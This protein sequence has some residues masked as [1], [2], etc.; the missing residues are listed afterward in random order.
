[1]AV[2]AVIPARYGSTRFPGKLMEKIQGKTLLQHTF[3]NTV[4]SACFD[5]VIVA[6]DSELIHEH[7]KEFGGEAATTSS[8][9]TTGTDRVAEAIASHKAYDCYDIVFN[10]QGDEPNVEPHVFAE[11]LKQLKHDTEA[12][13]ATAATPFLY[14]TEAENPSC[15]KVVLDCHQ[16]ALYFSR[17]LIPSG[18]ENSGYRPDIAYYHHLGIYAFRRT[19]LPIYTK[20]PASPLQLAECLEQLKILENGYKIAVAVVKSSAMG[21]NT[22]EDIKKMEK[23]R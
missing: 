8:S 23:S 18:K 20:L 7:V 3:E 4:N 11:V 15:V 21:I 22:H 9:C 10:V 13:M 14:A 5:K 2:L 6:T 16:R 12:V 1:M 17:A 19:F